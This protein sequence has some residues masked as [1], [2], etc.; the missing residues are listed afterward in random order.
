M[1]SNLDILRFAEH[2]DN[3][4]FVFVDLSKPDSFDSVVG[5]LNG[6]F[7]VAAPLP[8]AVSAI[9]LILFLPSQTLLVQRIGERRFFGPCN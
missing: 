6:V 2:K 1:V 4:E 8:G 9:L 7:H 5:G 3:L